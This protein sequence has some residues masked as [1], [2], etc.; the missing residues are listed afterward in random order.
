M[1]ICRSEL[2]FC[3]GEQRHFAIADYI[4]FFYNS[5]RKHSTLGYLSPA[6]YE[7]K[8]DNEVAG[9]SRAA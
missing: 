6:A 2:K 9:M 3:P 5:R 7:R 4:E 8:Y 1:R